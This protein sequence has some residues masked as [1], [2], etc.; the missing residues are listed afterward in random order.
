MRNFFQLK[1][2]W[3]FLQRNRLFTV[4]NVFGFAVSLAFVVLIGL[5]VQQELAVNTRQPNRDRTYRLVGSS[6]SNFAPFTGADLMTRYPEIERYTCIVYR[7]GWE[8]EVEAE[9]SGTSDRYRGTGFFT[10]SSFFRTFSFPFVEGTPDQALQSK[11]EVVLTESYARQLFGDRPALGRTISS[12]VFD[13]LVVCGVVRDFGK[14]THFTNPDFILWVSNLNAKFG[15]DVLTVTNWCGSEV[16]FKAHPGADLPAKTADLDQYLHSNQNYWL[17]VRDSANHPGFERL[18]EV[19]L[20]QK[21]TFSDSVR[22]NDSR[23][24]MVLGITALVILFFAVIN[25]I[26]LSVAQSGFRAKEAATRRLLGGSRGSLFGGFVLESVLICFVSFVLGVLL[27]MTIEPWFR[28]VM[29]TDISIKESFTAG[30]VALALAGVLVIGVI[31]GLVPASVLTQF[32]PID[33]VRGTFRRQTKM[34]YSKVLIGFQY[35]ITIALIGCTI[36]IGR[37]I[38][39]MCHSDLG[40]DHDNTLV[41]SC[42]PGKGTKEGL[43]NVLH[44]IPGVEQVGFTAGSPVTWSNNSTFQWKGKNI[45]MQMIGVDSSAFNILGFRV[46]QRTGMEDSQVVWLNTVAWNELELT[47][48]NPTFSMGDNELK[49]AGILANYHIAD[50][51]KPIGPVMIFFIDRSD[52]A[53]N[54]IVRVSGEN[55]YAVADR[56]VQEYMEYN[57]GTS[58]DSRFMDDMIQQQ[59]EAQQRMAEMVTSFSLL[60]V[61]ISALGMLAMSTYFMRQRAQ[62]VAVRKVFGATNREVLVRLM[63]SFLRLVLVA[64]V[65]AVPMIWYFMSDW[66]SGYAYR[67]PL[68]WSIFALAGAAAFGVAFLTLLWQSLKA[69]RANPVHALHE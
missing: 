57:G 33:V 51:E 39:F 2:F 29:Q 64:F 69:T 42:I 34:V 60:A 4:I 43:W 40:F 28:E 5:Y 58:V 18:E 9:A 49:V 53:S 67:I 35:C 23:F 46:L 25:Y 3:N 20:S 41:M 56:I 50:M 22:N 61:L 30:N 37:Q 1:S 36:T 15:L 55:P 54:L 17:F 10:D 27:A 59:Y 13:E 6:R 12:E 47:D 66:L 26:N 32:K 45:S 65:V 52:W 38:D 31:S 19:Y 8:L 62:E 48:D 16:Y 14:E 24:L 7:D 68:T 11:N 63:A 21:S 44:A